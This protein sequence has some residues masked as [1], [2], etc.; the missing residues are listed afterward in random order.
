MRHFHN[1][2]EKFPLIYRYQ[3]KISA[4]VQCKSARQTRLKFERANGVKFSIVI[5][6]PNKHFFMN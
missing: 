2:K 4:F 6:L 5:T 1:K 3:D